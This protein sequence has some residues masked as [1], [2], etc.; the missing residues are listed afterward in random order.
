MD[1]KFSVH[2][3]DLETG[4]LVYNRD[5]YK[6]MKKL[7]RKP[8]VNKTALIEIEYIPLVP[9]FYYRHEQ[10]P[11]GLS[12]YIVIKSYSLDLDLSF[13]PPIILY[14]LIYS[15]TTILPHLFLFRL[16]D[17]PNALKIYLLNK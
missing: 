6:F 17:E 14:E 2:E 8:V 5:F 13:F 7:A 16:K 15:D 10:G 1:A 3:L 4:E 9:V 11:V 12:E